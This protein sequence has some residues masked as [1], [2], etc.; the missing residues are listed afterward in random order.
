M[1]DSAGGFTRSGEHVE[2]RADHEWILRSAR[3]F[4]VKLGH[5]IAFTSTSSSRVP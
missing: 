3:S 4:D 2:T 1:L 5:V